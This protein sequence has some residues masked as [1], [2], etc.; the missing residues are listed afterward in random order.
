MVEKKRS[1]SLEVPAI[2]L[3]PGTSALVREEV[4]R[5]RGET[6]EAPRYGDVVRALVQ[7][8]LALPPSHV[9]VSLDAAAEIAGVSVGTL[10]SLRGDDAPAYRATPGGR[11]YPLAALLRWMAADLRVRR[12]LA[13]QVQAVAWTEKPQDGGGR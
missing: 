4:Q 9:E 6:G 8:G 7:G 12:G 10:L 1:P 5:R 2:R 13:A 11:L 3:D